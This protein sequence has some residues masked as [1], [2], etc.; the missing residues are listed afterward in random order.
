[1][2]ELIEPLLPGP[3]HAGPSPAAARSSASC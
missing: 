1:L 2:L 3:Q